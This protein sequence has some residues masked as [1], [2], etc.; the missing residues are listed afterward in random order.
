MPLRRPLAWRPSREHT[1]IMRPMR[2]I[3][4]T[5]I[6]SGLLAGGKVWAAGHSPE[7]S[8]DRIENASPPQAGTKG[9]IT[10][11]TRTT[12]SKCVGNPVTPLCAIE[13]YIACFVRRKETLCNDVGVGVGA[14]IHFGEAILKEDYAVIHVMTVNPDMRFHEDA[15]PGNAR[16][17]IYVRERLARPGWAENHREIHHFWL[18]LGPKNGRWTILDDL[19][20]YPNTDDPPPS[21]FLLRFGGAGEGD[22]R[23]P[24]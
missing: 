6:L 7:G 5:L 13:T 2:A 22:G 12:T 3:L 11:D 23:P 24:R 15:K 14:K 16:F 8:R 10:R 9:R 17:N 19:R 18:L 1:P 20:F 21:E 4:T